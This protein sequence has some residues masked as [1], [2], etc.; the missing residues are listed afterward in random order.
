MS[1]QLKF[2]CAM[3]SPFSPLLPLLLAAPITACVLA[4]TDATGSI[5][6]TAPRPQRLNIRLGLDCLPTCAQIGMDLA[7][8]GR[9]IAAAY[10]GSG[11]YA[12]TPSDQVDWVANVELRI[13]RV[14]DWLESK[15]CHGSFG[16]L[17]A[18]WHDS[19]RMTTTFTG[20]DGLTRQRIETAAE[21]GYRC[22]LFLAP[23]LAFGAGPD[24]MER[25]IAALTQQTIARADPDRLPRRVS[26][27]AGGQ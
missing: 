21:I 1:P 20:P 15:Y 3:R 11:R 10:R 24:E 18:V 2:D 16:L 27:P 4:H 25:T 14:N 7:Q 9:T 13:E 26:R 23:A 12:V 22:H 17:P 5:V 8:A 6:T 19:V